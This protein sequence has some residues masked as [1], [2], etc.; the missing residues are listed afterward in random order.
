MRVIVK[1]A[2][3]ELKLFLREPT[4][5]VFTFAFPVVLLFVMGEIFGGPR[6]QSDS[7]MFTGLA[8]L[9]YYVPAYIALACMSVGIIMLPARLTSYRS[10]GVLRRFRASLVPVSAVLGSQVLAGLALATVGALLVWLFGDLVYDVRLPASPLQVAAA[11]LIS[12]AA[13]SAMGTLIGA[14]LRSARAAQG[15]GLML[16]FVML[17][18]SGAGPPVEVMSDTMSRIAD[19]LPLTY[20]VNALQDAWNGRAWDVRD[21]LVLGGIALVA[22]WLSL[23]LYGW[24]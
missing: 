15:A 21:Y 18:L 1:L 7:G 20:A 6:F 24:D 9:D 3:V 2:W 11:F 17:F 23:R 5:L 22:G 14:V 12:V 16:F 10:G 13:F 8:P 4:T 19:F